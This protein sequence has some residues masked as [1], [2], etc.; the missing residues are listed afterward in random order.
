VSQYREEGR[1]PSRSDTETQANPVART[2]GG[3]SQPTPVVSKD[4]EAVQTLCANPVLANNIT[5][6]LEAQMNLP[7]V[8]A[9]VYQAKRKRRQPN[10]VQLGQGYAKFLL[11]CRSWDS[12]QIENDGLLTITLSAS[13]KHSEK[14]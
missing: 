6:L 10:E 12:L 7:G 11:L 9:D 5:E 14:K 4:S 3:Q 8:V 13:D 1:G 2:N